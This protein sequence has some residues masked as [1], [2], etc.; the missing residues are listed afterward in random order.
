MLKLVTTAVLLFS[1]VC[2]RAAVPG[3]PLEAL[4]HREL[5]L[6]FEPG[7]RAAAEEIAALYPAVK[8]E[9]EALFGWHLHRRPTIV[10]IQQE[11]VFEKLSGHPMIAAYA[12]P[13]QN[14]VVMDYGRL[15]T[16]P[17]R[18]R[19]VFKHELVHLL[20]HE[21]LD[22]AKLPK[23]FEEGVAQWASGGVADLL[24]QPQPSLL[25]QALLSGDHIPL[26]D[27]TERFPSDPRSLLLAYE[28]SRSLVTF[29][30]DTYGGENIT[31]ILESIK[32]GSDMDAAF[33]HALS[34]FP[35]Q[36]ERRWVQERARSPVWLTY[37]AGHLYTF[38]FLLG[39]LLTVLGFWRYWQ[40][41]RSYVDDDE[42]PES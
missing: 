30:A 23:W 36:I 28:E 10:L 31:A 42:A 4:D 25:D 9:L 24:D 32:R 35:W 18:I 14:L 16:R 17:S 21:N 15:A 40:K 33:Y 3:L 20:L 29:V 1:V 22:G 13:A 19:S 6:R 39:A 11:S 12:V 5:S 2:A 41:K 26:H 8:S 27:L 37:L 7:L 34:A 38:L